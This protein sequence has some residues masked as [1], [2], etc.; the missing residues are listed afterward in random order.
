[1][2]GAEGCQ[3]PQNVPVHSGSE[4][5]PLWA[6]GRGHSGLS[7]RNLGLGS[8]PG[9]QVHLA[10]GLV[11]FCQVMLLPGPRF[12]HLQNGQVWGLSVAVEKGGI[13]SVQELAEEEEEEPLLGP[14]G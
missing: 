4:S 2:G 9:F 5:C 12:P 11:H 6:E 7:G 1:M 8:E 3:P 13:G 14:R 10:P